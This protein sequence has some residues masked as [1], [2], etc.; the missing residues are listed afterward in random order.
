VGRQAVLRVFAFSLR[1]V[2]RAKRT[3]AF[4]A[5][6][7]LPVVLALVV[8]L[9]ALASPGR[10]FDGLAVFGNII[11]SFGLQFLI[12]I[13]ALFYGTSVVSEEV[14]GK[15]LTYLT[16][17]P[18][19]KPAVV[20]GKYAAFVLSLI[21]LVLASTLVS[22]LILNAGRLDYGPAW[23]FLGKSLIALGLGIAAYTAFFTLVGT[24]LKKSV[25][26]GFFFAFGWENIVQYF[27]GSTQKFTVMHYLKSL[28][29]AVGETSRSKLAAFLTFRLEP[30]PAGIA[31]V[32]LL[33]LTAAFLGLACW[34]FLR[35]EYLFDEG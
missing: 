18:L 21:V 13:L 31:V 4:A 20:L 23:S 3:K 2:R 28:L 24:F 10:G 22:F 30:S 33:V 32:T 11:V 5:L 15:T 1:L 25:L 19:P 7:L 8:R 35:K 29:P 27:P 14:E 17:R 34:I 16:T 12:L 6:C 26:F 9:N